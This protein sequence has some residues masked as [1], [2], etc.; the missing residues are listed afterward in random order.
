MS[1]VTPAED[2]TMRAQALRIADDLTAS[3]DTPMTEETLIGL[4]DQHTGSTREQ[5]YLL[6]S[7]PLTYG[8]T[9][10]EYAADVRQ[11]MAQQEARGQR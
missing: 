3:P 1:Q 8:L 11:V 10:G 9:Q 2:A 6:A 5:E 4:A 7:V